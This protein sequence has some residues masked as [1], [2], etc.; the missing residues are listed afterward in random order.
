LTE[1]AALDAVSTNASAIV[2][3][4]REKLSGGFVAPGIRVIKQGGDC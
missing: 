4:N 3:R 2:I 1:V